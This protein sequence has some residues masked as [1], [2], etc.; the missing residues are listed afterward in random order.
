VSN[1]LALYGVEE[2]TRGQSP[3]AGAALR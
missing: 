2:Q 1:L 3:E